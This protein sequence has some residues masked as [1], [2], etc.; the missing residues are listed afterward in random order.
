MFKFVKRQ[1][2]VVLKICASPSAVDPS[3]IFCRPEASAE[4]VPRRLLASGSHP[5]TPSRTM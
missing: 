4:G 2:E 5:G 1:L 3:L